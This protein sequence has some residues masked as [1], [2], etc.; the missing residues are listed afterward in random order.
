MLNHSVS[1]NVINLFICFTSYISC[2]KIVSIIQVCFCVLGKKSKKMKGKTLGLTE[3]LADGSTGPGAGQTV[4]T[5][6]S[7]SWADDVE[8]EDG[9]HFFF[10]HSSILLISALFE[11]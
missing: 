1:G 11:N 8:N 10:L 4:I 5:R 9:K 6:K 3:F 7:S 2:F